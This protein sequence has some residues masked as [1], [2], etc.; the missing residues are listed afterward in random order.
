M[1]SAAA[2]RAPRVALLGCGTVGRGVARLLIDRA[3][4]FGVEVVRILVRDRARDRGVDSALFTDRFD[5]VL[6]ARPDL[7]I[8]LLG[9]VE[10]AARYVTALLRRA[11]PVVTANKT[12][13]A[14]RGGDLERACAASGAV[15]ACEAA[16]CAGVPVLACLRHLGADRV[17]AIRGIVNGSCNYILTRMEDAGLTLAQALEEAARRGLVEPDPSA[18]LS[19]RDSAEKLCVLARA[20]GL[21]D[22]G[23]RDV[24]CAGIEGITPA[25]IR[26]AARAGRVI[27]LLAEVEPGHARV[28][29]VL[30]SRDHPLA[31]VRRED[32]GVF[33]EAELAGS[34]F[35]RG[36]GAGPGPTASGVLGDVA[37][38]LGRPARTWESPG[39]APEPIRRH[40][41]RVQGGAITPGRVLGALRSRNLL[42][43]Q[44]ELEASAAVVHTG[45]SAGD[46]V[47]RCASD[48]G[49]DRLVMPV[50]D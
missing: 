12:L 30:L 24:P 47:H 18:D 41:F 40:Q 25:D 32:N 33:I 10:P 48:L 4:V 45:P 44:I 7:A 37:R 42:P 20:A 46:P 3:E 2:P 23:P 15:L 26:A 50:V 22:L 8:E 29:P 34:L 17:R 36:P 35:L 28:G 21:A 6:D 27:R 39:P 16:V 38:I 13:L 1:S 14:H 43:D 49:T 19:G 9:G 11:I 31:G 5:D